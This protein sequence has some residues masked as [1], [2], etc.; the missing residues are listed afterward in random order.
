M[1]SDKKNLTRSSIEDAMVKA[2]K[3]TGTELVPQSTDATQVS[4]AK[5]RYLDK[6]IVLSKTTRIPLNKE[7]LKQKHIFLDTEDKNTAIA[8]SAYRHLRTN[9][10][11]TLNAFGGQTLLVTGPTASVGKTTTA[12]NLAINIARHSQRTALLVDLDLRKPDLH[13]VFDFEPEF[14]VIDI[15]KGKTPLEDVLVSPQIERLTLLPG[16]E[17]YEDSSELLSTGAMSNLLQ[18]LKSRYPERLV[19][20]DS[21]PVLGGDH[22]EALSASVDACLIVV[23]KTN[24]KH[25]LKETLRRVHD[26]KIAGYVLNRSLEAKFDRYYY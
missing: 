10:L 20:I 11:K 16:K 17:A 24:R 9:I 26:I 7:A 18:D 8:I 23:D 14:G 15:I 4:S 25:E 21:P 2:K 22:V 3:T 1:S 6:N 13:K 5:I 12:I 19:I